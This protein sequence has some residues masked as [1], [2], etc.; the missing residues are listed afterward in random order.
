MALVKCPECQKDISD[1]VNK[2]PHCGYTIRNNIIVK[3]FKT[4]KI[5]CICFGLVLVLLLVLT[6]LLTSGYRRQN[7]VVRYLENRGYSCS[8]NVDSNGDKYKE[9][10]KKNDGVKKTIAVYAELGEKINIEYTLDNN[11]KY[12][13]YVESSA[14]QFSRSHH[15]YIKF[16]DGSYE[17][18]V[19]S[20]DDYSDDPISM[21]EK[22]TLWRT[23]IYDEEINDFLREYEEIYLYNG[24]ELGE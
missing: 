8:S 20:R 2:C 23:D 13:L 7:K 21:G 19:K 24:L 15:S 16:D 6:L 11:G 10:F 4:H 17:E 14:Y 22:F 9:C 5:L 18:F 1:T 3:F 12:Q